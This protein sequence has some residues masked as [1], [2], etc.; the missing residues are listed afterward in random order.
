MLFKLYG[1]FNYS[2]LLT[3]ESIVYFALRRRV[4]VVCSEKSQIKK[5][6]CLQI[7]E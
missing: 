1:I 2:F 6:S 4:R 5:E 3:A 7:Y